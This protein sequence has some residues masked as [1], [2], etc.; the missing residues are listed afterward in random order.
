[1]RRVRLLVSRPNFLPAGI[2]VKGGGEGEAGVPLGW[3][4][5]LNEAN[6]DQ[7]AQP[8]NVLSRCF[9]QPNVCGHQLIAPFLKKN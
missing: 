3:A 7:A 2:L 9:G 8:I 6:R 5:G 1:M 4:W